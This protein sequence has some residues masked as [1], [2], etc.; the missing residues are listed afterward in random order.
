[1]KQRGY[2]QLDD[3]MYFLE[4]FSLH[5]LQDDVLEPRCQRMWQLLRS[6]LL[7]YL[8]LTVVDSNPV[9]PGSSFSEACR[10]LA[11]DE[12]LEYAKLLESEVSS[13]VTLIAALQLLIHQAP[14]R[15]QLAAHAP[16]CEAES[17]QQLACS[18][19]G[20]LAGIYKAFCPLRPLPGQQE[21]PA[22][23]LTYNLHILVCRLH[24][25]EEA[26]GA[27][28]KDLEFW[29]E[30]NIQELKSAVKYRTTEWPEKIAVQRALVGQRLHLLCMEHPQVRGFDELCPA[31]RA[32]AVRGNVDSGT[33]AHGSQL[34]GVGKPVSNPGRQAA[35]RTALRRLL[36]TAR[37]AGW[38]H[39]RD[40]D[41]AALHQHTYAS[42]QGDE[43]VTSAANSRSRSRVSFYVKVTYVRAAGADVYVGRVS[44]FL[45]VEQAHSPTITEPGVL[46][47]A[48][49]D[50]FK[51][52][53]R[54]GMLVVDESRPKEIDY[55]VEVDSIDTKVLIA[56]AGTLLHCIEYAK[57]SGMS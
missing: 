16:R 57:V 7:H 21:M 8:R 23:L 54:N 44:E 47:L 14:L 6:S 48:C 51:A 27:V 42:K 30:R 40:T 53:R 2:W 32:A 17:W 46:R 5:V 31:Y 15:Q 24:K 12:L 4:S 34:L 49:C 43:V 37:P 52:Q 33:S 19:L 10:T 39:Q 56:R 18:K 11:R 38:S 26:C 36:R 29:V 55:F 41:S 9:G 35:L 28:A 50:L 1:M 20:A 45:R 25:Q 3:F 22:E 13:Y